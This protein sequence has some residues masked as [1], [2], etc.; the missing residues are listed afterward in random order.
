[1]AFDLETLVLL[2]IFAALVRRRNLVLA[3]ACGLRPFLYACDRLRPLLFYIC[4][5]LAAFGHW[6]GFLIRKKN[7]VRRPQG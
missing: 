2:K 6:R 4:F 3:I 1:V 5:L 7:G